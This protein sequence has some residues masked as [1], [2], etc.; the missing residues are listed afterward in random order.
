MSASEIEIW[1]RYRA[2][3]NETIEQRH[4]EFMKNMERIN[5]PLGFK[6]LVLPEAPDCGANLGASFSVKG[7]IKGL[8]FFGR[9]IFRNEKYLS[10]DTATLDDFILYEFKSTNKFLD[11]KKL[12][13]DFLPE[14]IVA[15]RGYKAFVSYGYY[16]LHYVSG[17]DNGYDEN[18]Y[19]IET[20][21]AYNQL[22]KNKNIEVDG[23]NNIF[24]LHP[25]QYWGNELCLKA[26]GYGSDEVIKRL[27]DKVIKAERLVDGVYLVLN[28]D[29]NIT[30]DQFVEMNEKYKPILGL[31]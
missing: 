14:I 26:L 3:H 10:E 23:R 5:Q 21:E 13:H 29:P 31:I 9:Y 16:P 2:T 18:G 22:R 4:N 25:A 7:L 12:L 15:Y 6:G 8:R 24:T 27:G 28:D 19:A 20:N 1:V 17:G 30:Y 11:Y